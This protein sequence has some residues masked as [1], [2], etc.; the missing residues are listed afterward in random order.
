[1]KTVGQKLI[2]EEKINNGMHKK[3]PLSAINVELS[4]ELNSEVLHFSIHLKEM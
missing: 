2:K 1:L 3:R 4:A